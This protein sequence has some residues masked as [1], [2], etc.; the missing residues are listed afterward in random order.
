MDLDKQYDEM[1]DS[2]FNLYLNA[3]FV[4]HEKEV[5]KVLNLKAINRIRKAM[6]RP[7]GL[8]EAHE[9]ILEMYEDHFGMIF[10]HTAPMES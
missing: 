5:K 4:V 2:F 9:D 7:V 6:R 10:A 3:E 8:P 1:R